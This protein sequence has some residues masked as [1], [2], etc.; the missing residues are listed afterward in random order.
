MSPQALAKSRDLD[1][2][3]MITNARK[4]SGISQGAVA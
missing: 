1:I 2:D 4:A 3:T